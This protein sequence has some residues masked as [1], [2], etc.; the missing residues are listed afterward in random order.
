METDQSN[1]ITIEENTLI[2]SFMKEVLFLYNEET[3]SVQLS[4]TVTN[5]TVKGNGKVVLHIF[6]LGTF[7]R[8]PKYAS[9]N[10]PASMPQAVVSPLPIL[11]HSHLPSQRD[12]KSRSILSRASRHP[13]V[14]C[15][16]KRVD[17]SSVPYQTIGNESSASGVSFDLLGKSHTPF[18]APLSRINVF[19]GEGR[20]HRR[21]RNEGQ[22][23]DSMN[24]QV[25]SSMNDQ[26]VSSMNGQ[27]MGSV[28]GQVVS[29]VSGQAM[30]SVSGQR[31]GS[32]NGQVV[33]SVNGQVVSSVSGQVVSSV[34]GQ[35]MNSTN[36]QAVN[37]MNNRLTNSTYNQ[38]ANTQRSQSMNSINQAVNS[39][40]YRLKYSTNNQSMNSSNLLMNSNNQSINSTTNPITTPTN[41]PS[42]HTN[43]QPLPVTNQT[44]PADPLAALF[45]SVT[46]HTINFNYAS[47]T[48]QP[49]PY[50]PCIPEVSNVDEEDSDSAFT[51]DNL[52]SSDD[53][54]CFQRVT[55]D[56]SVSQS[57]SFPTSSLQEA[58]SLESH[59]SMNKRGNPESSSQKDGTTHS[60]ISS[61]LAGKI[62]S[63][64]SKS[65]FTY[66]RIVSF[67]LFS[68]YT[69]LNPIPSLS[70]HSH[71]TPSLSSDQHALLS[72]LRLS[73]NHLQ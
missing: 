28:N 27:R 62:A 2:D 30:S 42:L 20:G 37:S 58:S 57:S 21:V 49:P 38:A 15:A 11:H 45:S 59:D 44:Q 61:S 23:M 32:M 10:Q 40:K 35:A 67:P 31:M 36:N 1:Q 47:S 24:D 18:S 3:S 64:H 25:V 4:F 8:Y 66:S 65:P 73:S 17:A 60:S 69:L 63:S 55:K 5:D 48:T 33:S 39:M 14:L 9:P 72:I 54:W 22:M 51:H 34:S 41:E 70:S 56:Q 52:S 53:E 6:P 50:H 68:R 29:S 43:Q 19:E 46:P 7:P 16:G 26:V 13:S 12:M 71:H